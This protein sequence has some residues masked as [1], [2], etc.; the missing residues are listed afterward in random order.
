MRPMAGRQ[1]APKG[2]RPNGIGELDGELV[3]I[4][5]GPGIADG[6]FMLLYRKSAGLVTPIG[7]RLRTCV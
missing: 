5:Y 4:L 2:M 6:S 3:E 7:P 1:L